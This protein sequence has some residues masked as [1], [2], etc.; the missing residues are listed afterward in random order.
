MLE[1]A[2]QELQS[3]MKQSEKPQKQISKELGLSTSVISQFLNG[4]YTGNNE[5]VAKAIHQYLSVSKERLNNVQTVVFYEELQNTRSVLFACNYAHTK[6][7]MTLVSGDAGSGKTTALEFYSKN[8]TGV[9]MVTANSCTTSPN[10]ILK[11]ICGK[12]SKQVPSNK[13]AMMETIVD[14]LTDSNRLLIVDEADHLSLQAMQAI[15]NINDLAHIGI[16]LSGND[17]IYTQMVQG[18]RV[19]EF[20]QIRT[21]I[22]VRQRVHNSF[23]VEEIK[24]IFPS[25]SQECQSFMLSIAEKESLRTAIEICDVAVDLATHTKQKLT[26]KMLKD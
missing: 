22:I 12:I 3:F 17:K 7:K 15:H 11:M 13:S 1:T 9:I 21:R 14:S 2:R 23:D 26:V 5:E 16:V 10:G 6:N 8:N 18:R 24:G 25:L 20:E 19:G 4:T